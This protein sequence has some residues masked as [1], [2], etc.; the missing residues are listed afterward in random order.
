[1]SEVLQE[2]E[3]PEGI[4]ETVIESQKLLETTLG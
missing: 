2:L 1:M 3:I 4:C